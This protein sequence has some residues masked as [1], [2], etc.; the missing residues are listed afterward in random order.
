[1]SWFLEDRKRNDA[2]CQEYVKV[3]FASLD[4][5]RVFVGA[6]RTTAG[7]PAW[8]AAVE[9]EFSFRPAFLT[10]LASLVAS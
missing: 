2:S 5:S 9:K 7:N 6:A 1:M 3:C 8:D 4:F 10:K